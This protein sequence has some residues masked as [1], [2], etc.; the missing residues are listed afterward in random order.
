MLEGLVN[1]GPGLQFEIFPGN[2]L[3]QG[4]GQ[5]GGKEGGRIGRNAE[6]GFEEL[7][8]G[9]VDLVVRHRLQGP[10]DRSECKTV[11]ARLL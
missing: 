10:A 2:V 7:V 9:L 3:R 5:M 6:P 8:M 4:V 1:K 11:K